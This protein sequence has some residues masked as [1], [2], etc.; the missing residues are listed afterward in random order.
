MAT[1]KPTLK[2]LGAAARRTAAR[3][4]GLV[5]RA[6]KEARVLI[7]DARRI[8]RDV[9]RR[10]ERTVREVEHGAERMLNQLEA[11]AAKMTEPVLGKVFASRREVQTLTRRLAA[12]EKIVGRL[13]ASRAAAA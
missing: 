7:G 12:L 2:D 8:R 6:G 1:R 11:R 5:S 9:R 3:G 4:E 10:A 13:A